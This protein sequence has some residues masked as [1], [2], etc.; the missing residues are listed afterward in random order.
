MASL[1]ISYSRKD[2]EAAR[3][4]SDAFQSQNLDFWIDWA[5]IEPTVDWWL[6]IEKGIEEAD[7]FVFLLS[8]D[9]ITSEICGW[10]IEHAV[11]NGKRLIP[12]KVRDINAKEAPAHLRPLN[13]ISLCETD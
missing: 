6:A 9:S 10:E 13:W 3:K 8:P 11:K 1:F 12:V 2:I 4:L 5:G 7:T